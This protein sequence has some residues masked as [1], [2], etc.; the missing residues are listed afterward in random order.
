MVNDGSDPNAAERKITVPAEDGQLR[1]WRNTGL[2]AT[3]TTLDSDILS[4]E[5]DEDLDNGSRPAG[6]IRLSSTTDPSTSYLQDFGSTYGTAPATH[7]LTMYRAPSGALVFGAGTTQWAWG[8]DAVHDGSSHTDSRIRQATVNLFADMG[9]QP[10][11][12]ISGLTPATA[13]TDTTR[14]TS[15]ITSPTGGSTLQPGTAVTITGTASDVGGRVG[16]VEVSTDGGTSWKRASGR[17]NWTYSWTPT[18]AGSFNIKSRAADDSLNLE[19]PGA[20]VNVTVGSGGGGSGT[21]SLWS[22]CDHTCRRDG[23]GYRRH[24]GRGEVRSQPSRPDHRHP[25]LQGAAEPR[26]SCRQSV[27]LDGYATA[28]DR[29]LRQRDRERLAAGQFR[30]P[31]FGDCGDHLRRLVLR[32]AGQVFGQRKLLQLRLHERTA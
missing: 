13:S 16:G 24:R 17:S 32:P 27:E 12:L 29:Y 14:P 9:V 10:S 23:P 3:A 22:R 31:G 26:H 30:E 20:G 5:W 11:T 15:T 7:S 4:Y 6:L 8:L 2:G 1:F 21:N 19:T 25:L 28:G 18:V